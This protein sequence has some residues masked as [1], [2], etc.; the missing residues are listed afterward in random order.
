MN[1]P[2]FYLTLLFYAVATIGYLAFLVWVK[3]PLWMASRVVLII[4][5]LCHT[6]SIV[7]RYVEAGYTPVTNRFESLI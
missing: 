1:V 6:A 4:G 3:K 5:F 2:L 7:V